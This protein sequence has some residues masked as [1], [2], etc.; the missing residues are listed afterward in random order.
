MLHPDLGEFIFKTPSGIIKHGLECE[1][2]IFGSNIDQLPDIEVVLLRLIRG[3]DESQCD[4]PPAIDHL[5][6]SEVEGLT[7][8]QETVKQAE[9]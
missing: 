8:V 2:C 6:S 5:D 1:F 3:Q 9:G 4:P 7:L